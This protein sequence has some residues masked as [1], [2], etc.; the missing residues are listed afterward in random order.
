MSRRLACL[1]L[2]LSFLTPVTRAQQAA[3]PK[4]AV[5]AIKVTYTKREVMIPMRDGVK[6]FTAVYEPKDTT[7]SYPFI[8]TRTPYSVSPYGVDAYRSP[9]HPN[10][11]FQKEGFIFVFQDVRGRFMSEGVFNNMTPHID[12]KRGNQDIDESSDT[13]DTI[14]WLIKNV[15]NHNGKVGQWGISYPGFYA[16][17]GMIDAHPAL[18]AVSPQAPVS[19]WFTGDDFGRNGTLWLPHG[20]NFMNVFGRPRPKPTTEWSKGAEQGTPDGYDFFLRLG[21]LPNADTKYFKGEVAF[22]QEM[23]SHGTNDAFW[24][25][26]N[27]RPHLKNIKPAVLTVG[28]WFD[29]ENLFGALQVYEHVE[30]LNP[31]ADNKLVMGPW[32]HGGWARTSGDKLGHALFGSKTSEFYQSE[33]EFPFFM[34]HLKGA[35]DPKL[36]EARVFETGKNQWRSFDVWPP[37]SV[38]KKKLFLHEGGKLSFETPKEPIGA[39][40]FVSDP[41]KPVPY[42]ESVAI[43]MT[44]EYM[45]DDQRFASRRPDVLS[46]TS[47]SLNEDITLA[48]SLSPELFVAITGT[49]AD[50]VVKLIDVFPDG[51]KDHPEL[52]KDPNWHRGAY[53]MLIRGEV[54][55]GKF[56]ESLEKPKAFVPNQVTK[57]A[58]RMNDI[59][60]TF[61]KGHRIMIQIQST[62]FPLMDRNPQRF[63]DIHKAKDSDFKAQTH[64]IFHNAHQSSSLGVSVLR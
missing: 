47:E 29:A 58:Y 48:G 14:D 24:K 9:L 3:P 5:E 35:V 23:M 13:F 62:W 7:R 63:L 45:T 43:G 54:M 28:G 39:S 38:E 19:D 20:F 44:K 21:A 27:I 53:Q 50:W 34:H 6:L 57:V 64:T 1:F 26:R 52:D 18:K 16:A 17:A 42:T 60:H 15:Q 40:R 10:P 4:E 56:R 31:G 11:L 22:W 46:F 25:S 36:P 2:T 33:I 55:R 41:N 12:Q 61:Q 59:L 51:E 32:I 37:A 8:L 49:D 30:K